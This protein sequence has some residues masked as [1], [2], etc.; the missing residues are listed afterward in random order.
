MGV[1][2]LYMEGDGTQAS[3]KSHNFHINSEN[4]KNRREQVAKTKAEAVV[5][6]PAAIVFVDPC[7]PNQTTR[8]TSAETKTMAFS[9]LCRRT[10]QLQHYFY[11]PTI[12]TK[13]GEI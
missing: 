9:D 8:K 2:W 7:E 12:T 6:L 10:S 5:G 1:S 3:N 13:S 4:K 11:L